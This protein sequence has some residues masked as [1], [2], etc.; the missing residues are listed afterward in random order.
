MLLKQKGIDCI[1]KAIIDQMPE[2]YKDFRRFEDAYMFVGSSLVMQNVI[3]F[4]GW[5]EYPEMILLSAEI[6]ESVLKQLFRS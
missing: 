1:A 5:E 3:D 4:D 2:Q 6:R